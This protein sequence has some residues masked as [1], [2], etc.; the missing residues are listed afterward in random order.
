MKSKHVIA[1]IPAAGSGSRMG[2]DIKKQYLRIGQKPILFYT[3]RQFDR[4]GAIEE[5]ILAVPEEELAFVASE[6][7]DRYHIHKV[8]KIV[9]GGRERQDSV[10][11]AFN[12]IDNTPDLV[13]IH[14]G[15]RPFVTAEILINAVQKTA[16]LGATVAG[17]PVAATIK[18]VVDGEITGTLKRDELWEIQTPQT[19]RFDWLKRAFEK[20]EAENFYATDDAG[21]LEHAG[22]TVYAIPGSRLNVKITHPDDLKLAEFLA[23]EFGTIL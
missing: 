15:I 12:A 4:C 13:M 2:N 6:I 9:A 23:N 20:A 16:E 7:V 21:L 10:R 22:F 1:L 3:L 14:D 5:I 8:K 11:A 17:I 18:R 19:F